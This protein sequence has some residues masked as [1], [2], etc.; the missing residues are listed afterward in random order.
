MRNLSVNKI[1]E[2]QMTSQQPHSMQSCKPSVC[3]AAKS[4]VIAATS[5]SCGKSRD[6]QTIAQSPQRMH[7]HSCMSVLHLVGE[8]PR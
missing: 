2:G 3:S 1:C 7:G 4:L 5:R 6:G 8:T